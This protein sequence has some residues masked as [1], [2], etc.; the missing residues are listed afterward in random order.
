[1]GTLVTVYRYDIKDT[2]TATVYRTRD[3]I[4]AMHG[5][6]RE[7]TARQVPAGEITSGGLWKPDRNP[8]T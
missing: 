1:M 4:L 8:V 6:V 2:P 3:S 7:D 5:V